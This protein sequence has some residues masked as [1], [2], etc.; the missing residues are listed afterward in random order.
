MTDAKHKHYAN[1]L[2]EKD[3]QD[4]ELLS[5]YKGFDWIARNK[6]LYML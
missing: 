3:N 2:R 4:D 1:L 6:N 5:T